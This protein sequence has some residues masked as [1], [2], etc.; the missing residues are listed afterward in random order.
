M[1]G[2]V[3]SHSACPAALR[4]VHLKVTMPVSGRLFETR[5]SDDIDIEREIVAGTQAA[6]AS[7]LR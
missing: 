1:I 6:P 3:I 2:D 7:A 4:A 5:A